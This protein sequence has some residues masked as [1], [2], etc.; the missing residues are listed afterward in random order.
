MKIFSIIAFILAF[1]L[2]ISGIYGLNIGPVS[3]EGL[4]YQQADQIGSY[5]CL[6]CI[7]LTGNTVSHTLT[8]DTINRLKKI[9]YP[10]KVWVFTSNDCPTCPDAKA[11][12][13]NF[14]IGKS[15]HIL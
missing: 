3:I 9:D 2:L 5:I 12:I 13:L 1:V 7:G 8:D 10:V 11:I 6:S 14:T 4:Q 15:Q